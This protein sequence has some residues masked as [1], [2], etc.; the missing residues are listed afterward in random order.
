MTDIGQHFSQNSGQNRDRRS[1]DEHTA[2][3]GSVR[4]ESRQLTESEQKIQT[5][6]EQQTDTGQDTASAVRRGLFQS[7]SMSD[8]PLSDFLGIQPTLHATKLKLVF[9]I[10]I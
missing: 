9:K 10:C 3:R 4:A 2:G 5:Q 8:P 6:S 1:P 7:R